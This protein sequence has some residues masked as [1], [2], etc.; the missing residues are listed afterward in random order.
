VHWGTTSKNIIDTALALQIKDTYGVVGGEIDAIAAELAR[1]ARAIA[2]PVM[3]GRTHGQHALPVTFGYKAAVWL[4]EVL[5]Q[6]S[7]WRRAGRACWW[8]S[9]GARSGP[10]PRSGARASPCRTASWRASA[11]ACP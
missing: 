10:W 6:R 11:W 4:D 9:W 2:T 8:G 1:L 5:R 3:A 7:A